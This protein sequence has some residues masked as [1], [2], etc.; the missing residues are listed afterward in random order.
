MPSQRSSCLTFLLA[1]FCLAL[2]GCNVV[3]T[4]PWRRT[5]ATGQGQ[6]AATSEILN[7]QTIRQFIHTS[8]GGNLVRITLSNASGSQPLAVTSAHIA[9]RD[10]GAGTVPGSDHVL[11]FGGVTSPSIPAGSMA[12]SDPVALR[13]APFADLAVSLYFNTTTQAVTGNFYP[14]Q[15]SYVASGDVAASIDF[16]STQAISAVFYLVSADVYP[17]HSASTIVAFGDSIVAGVGSTT[18]ANRRWPDVLATR[19]A[20]AGLDTGIA[21]EGL[22][23]NRLLHDAVTPYIFYGLSALNRF[24]RDALSTPG[25]RTI[26]VFIGLNDINAPGF[27]AP[28][29]EAVSADEIIAGYKLLIE[30]AHARNI[31]IL[32]A[33]L[34]P[35]GGFIAYADSKET[36]RQTVNAWL[37]TSNAFDGMFDFDMLLRDPAHPVQLNPDYDS[38]DHI[39]PNDRGYALLGNSIDLSILNVGAAQ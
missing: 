36:K 5:W 33:T 6:L 32:A 15:T 14:V 28:A 25:V 7:D 26:I 19:L 10:T 35:C 34:T 23:G 21:N 1:I 17:S 16:H 37:R 2:T 31:R 13:V 4:Q 20:A 39:H 9:L 11:T 27:Q 29:S 24:D 8:T 22:G 30:R 38:G 12:T 18:D 3:S